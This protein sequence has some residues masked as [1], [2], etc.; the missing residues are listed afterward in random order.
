VKRTGWI[1]TRAIHADDPGAHMPHV[2]VQ[3][4]VELQHTNSER[5]L[6]NSYHTV[7]IEQCGLME[8]R[9]EKA[10]RD[11]DRR[12][13]EEGRRMLHGARQGGG[14]PVRDT[15][16]ETDLLSNESKRATKVPIWATLNQ[17]S[18]AENHGSKQICHNFGA[19]TSLLIARL[20][21]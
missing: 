10:D 8:R 13:E 17:N 16:P 20:R 21:N 19:T 14:A 11:G 5:R 3:D 1:T 7:R 12:R 18:N 2:F 6:T 4:A 15:T 9:P